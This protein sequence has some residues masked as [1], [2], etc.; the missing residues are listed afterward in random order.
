MDEANNIN[1][2][3]RSSRNGF[4]PSILVD[5]DVIRENLDSDRAEAAQFKGACHVSWR[6]DDRQ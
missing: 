6:L 4:G 3:N 2:M 1:P 5:P